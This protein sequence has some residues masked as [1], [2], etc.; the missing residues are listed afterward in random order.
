MAITQN[1]ANIV[2]IGFGNKTL[3]GYCP[4]GVSI[5]HEADLEHIVCNGEFKTSLIKNKRHK[6]QF[7]AIIPDTA[8]GGPAIDAIV[9]GDLITIDSVIYFCES[10][11]VVLSETA[12]RITFSGISHTDEAYAVPGP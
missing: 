8:P 5:S 1:P 10:V 7:E 4:K 9:A 2:V 11:S 12:A 6:I 3:S